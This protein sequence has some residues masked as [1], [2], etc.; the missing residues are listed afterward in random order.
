M[1]LE[2]EG[3]IRARWRIEGT[4]I[5]TK[6]SCNSVRGEGGSRQWFDGMANFY[7]DHTGQIARIEVG[8]I[9]VLNV[10]ERY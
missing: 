8:T 2:A 7:V 9:I 6:L 10:N 3:V 1:V 4:G 5:L